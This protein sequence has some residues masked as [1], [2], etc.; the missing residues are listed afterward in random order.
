MQKDSNRNRPKE[1]LVDGE[2]LG[3]LDLQEFLEK[4]LADK[5]ESASDFRKSFTPLT[6][7]LGLNEPPRKVE[8]SKKPIEFLKLQEDFTPSASAVNEI[9]EEVKPLPPLPPLTGLIKKEEAQVEERSFTQLMSK[10]QREETTFVAPPRPKPLPPPMP[11]V[12]FFRRMLAGFIDFAF[13][14]VVMGLVLVV[15][16]NAVAGVSSDL[17]FRLSKE[18][19]EPSFVRIFL[20]E[21]IVGW[22]FYWAF[23]LG[24]AERSFGMWVWGMKVSFGE[25]EARGLRK[26]FRIF[27][28]FIFSLTLLPYM[29]LV[30]T[31]RGRNLVDLISGSQVYRV[32]N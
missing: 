5:T 18:I 10:P 26:G 12:G 13:M 17:V 16:A 21:Y 14:G 11:K 27:T 8:P 9:Y 6:D 22:F 30:V 28:S 15:T 31:F 1:A 2:V 19:F 29:L 4:E 7:G 3:L 23:C 25:G 32:G 20:A 24:F